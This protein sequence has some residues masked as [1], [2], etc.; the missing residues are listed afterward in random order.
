MTGLKSGSSQDPLDRVRRVIVVLDSDGKVTKINRSGAQ[1]LECD[2]E[3]IVGRNWFDAH[4]PGAHRDRIRQFH[5]SAFTGQSR[6]SHHEYSVL[7]ATGREHLLAWQTMLLRDGEGHPVG[8]LNSG[9]EIADAGESAD[10]RRRNVRQLEDMRFAL[11]E[12]AIVAETDQRG[13]I[14]YVNQRFCQTSGYSA[15]ELLGR[16]HRIVNSGYHPRSFFRDMWETISSGKV[17]RGE[18]RNRKKN[19]DFYWVETTI[20][21]FAGDD[22]TP[23]KYLGIRHDI[24]ERKRAEAEIRDRQALTQLGHMAA[25]VAHE[26]RNPLAGM[27]GALQI[28]GQRMPESGSDREVIATILERIGLL[29]VKVEELLRYARPAPPQRRRVSAPLLID[30]TLSL[31]TAD[32]LME[33][34]AVE[35]SMSDA[36]LSCDSDRVVESFTNI[37]LNAAEAM[38]GAGRIEII[39]RPKGPRY[40]ISIRDE[41]PGIPPANSEQIFEPFFSDRPNGTGLGLAIARQVIRAN[42]GGI[43]LRHPPDGGAEFVI[44]LPIAADP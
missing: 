34:V 21:P 35:R 44:D 25:V 17:W 6:V 5:R 29:D 31:L 4:L 2:S 1:L 43:E 39:G 42:G 19:G 9:V 11:D 14:H 13:I 7:D 26:V 10:A 22:G 20:V 15:D 33:Q 28:I 18:I 8:I 27:A 38:Q 24:T 40:I 41:G 36:D 30:Q 12:A 3:K 37:L 32:P 23:A 16:D